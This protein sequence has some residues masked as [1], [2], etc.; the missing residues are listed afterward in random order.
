[1][2]VDRHSFY[3]SGERWDQHIEKLDAADPEITPKSVHKPI[4]GCNA[5]D[6]RPLSEIDARYER[7]PSSRVKLTAAE[8]KLLK[9]PDWID[10]DEAD[11]ILALRDEKEFKPT[12]GIT[13][14]EHLR[15]HGRVVKDG[16]V[17]KG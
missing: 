10:E 7:L 13:F 17:V 15:R 16:R 8:R 2:Y 11:L 4:N 3:R 5:T 14:R 9:D 6:P 1:M 12:D